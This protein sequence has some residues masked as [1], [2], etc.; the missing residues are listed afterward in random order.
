MAKQFLLWGSLFGGL[1]V[2]LGAFGAHALKSILEANQRV[3]TFELASRYQFYHA[4]ALIALGL[5]LH[6][7]PNRPFI[8]GGYAFIIGMLIFSGSLYILS[9]TNIGVLGAITPI[10]GLALI[11]AWICMIW[12]IS[13]LNI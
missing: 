2:A 4:L 8:Y 3:D 12:G 10:G 7:F 6:H 1:A 5:L 11:I 13:Q 9:L